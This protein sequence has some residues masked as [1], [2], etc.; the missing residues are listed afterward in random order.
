MKRHIVLY[1]IQSSS[2]TE[3]VIAISIIAICFGVASLVFI[4]SLSTVTKYE[5]IRNQTEIQSEVLQ[6]LYQEKDSISHL[7][8]K[9]IEVTT[10]EEF[11]N[12]TLQTIEFRSL[13]GRMLW[14]QQ[15]L[16]EKK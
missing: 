15:L 3:V 9:D 11:T 7:F 13:S 5:D 8:L 6:Y 14:Q 4:R 16:K 10:S 1:R 12:D 2:L